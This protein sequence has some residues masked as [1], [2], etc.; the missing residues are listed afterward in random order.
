MFIPT[1][2]NYIDSAGTSLE[3]CIAFHRIKFKNNQLRLPFEHPENI[4][5]IQFQKIGEH[6]Y[7][8][9]YDKAMFWYFSHFIIPNPE[10]EIT[11]Y[12]NYENATNDPIDGPWSTSNFRPRHAFIMNCVWNCTL[13]HMWNL[14]DSKNENDDKRIY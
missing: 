2:N 13:E 14:V 11:N 3:N 5:S 12:Y 6:T 9:L 4:S 1:F 7:T 10:G 8:M